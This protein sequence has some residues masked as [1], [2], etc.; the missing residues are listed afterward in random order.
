[1]HSSGRGGWGGDARATRAAEFKERPNGQ[2]NKYLIQNLIFRV[3][4]ILNYQDQLKEIQKFPIPV[5]GATASVI[6]LRGLQQTP[7]Y[8]TDPKGIKIVNIIR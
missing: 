8:A 1:M 5:S 3:Q 6:T 2:Q 4:Q 7:S